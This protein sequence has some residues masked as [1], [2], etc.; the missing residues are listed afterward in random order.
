MTVTAADPDTK[1]L[2][3]LMLAE[4]VLP[5]A[6]YKPEVLRLPTPLAR[7]QLNAGCVARALPN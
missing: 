2:L 3:A 7:L 5:G 1:P 4:P 6:V